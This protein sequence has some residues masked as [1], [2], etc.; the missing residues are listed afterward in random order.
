MDCFSDCYMDNHVTDKDG[1]PR[2]VKFKKMTYLDLAN[3]FEKSSPDTAYKTVNRAYAKMCEW[4]KIQSI[5]RRNKCYY[6]ILK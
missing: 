6:K 1:N 4:L 2:K 5:L 3:T